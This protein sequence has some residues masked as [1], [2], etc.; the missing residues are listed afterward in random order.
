MMAPEINDQ[1][2]VPSLE[3]RVAT[4]ERVV[5]VLLQELR[6]TAQGCDHISDLDT[7]LLD[8]LK[9]DIDRDGKE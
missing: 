7:Q 6:V 9:S 1:S 3:I 4:L 2:R 8:D 5:S